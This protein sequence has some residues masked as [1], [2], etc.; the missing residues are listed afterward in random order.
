[1]DLHIL[2]HLII[3]TDTIR[4]NNKI[5]IFTMY[6]GQ[7]VLKKKQDQLHTTTKEVKEKNGKAT[8]IESLEGL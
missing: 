2:V 5:R 6:L 8:A 3:V 1:M 4:L 7:E